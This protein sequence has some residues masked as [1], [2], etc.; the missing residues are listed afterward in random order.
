MLLRFGVA[1]HLSIRD[2]QELSLVA[3]P[4]RD[5][6]AG[7]IDTPQPGLRLLPAALIYGANASGKSNFVASLRWLRGAVLRSHAEFRPD[8]GV[9]RRPF[10]LDDRSK[11]AASRWDIDFI[12]GGVP[13]HYEVEANDAAFVGERL[14]ARPEGRTQLWFD[15]EGCRFSF[16]RNL[17]GRNSTI[18][19]LTRSNSLFLST[20]MQNGHEALTA[21]GR[22]F[23]DLAIQDDGASRLAEPSPQQ[24]LDA[25]VTQI[26]AALGTGIVESRWTDRSL[27]DDL[28]MGSE[29]AADYLRTLLPGVVQA[30]LPNRKA[31]ELAHPDSNGRPRFFRFEDES[32]GTRRLIRLLPA[33]FPALDRGGTM[34]VDELNASLHT[35]ACETLLALVSLRRSNPK[36]AQLVATTHDTNLL[37]SKLLRR[38]QIWL[39]EKDPSGASQLYPL[40]DIHTRKGDNLARGYLQGRY[41]A[42][43]F[44]GSIADLLGMN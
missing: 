10:A 3:S 34:V 28:G 30:S 36:G 38:D 7:L 40:T 22:Y 1:N 6:E 35:Q 31:L 12:V 17:R 18:A 32:E 44:S 33:M 21:V 13:Y 16:G 24:P 37:H 8:G 25:R 19:A 23:L 2:R 29:G 39:V 9:P 15:R 43:P 42:V 41:G 11:G 14:L 26:L 5:D 27:I 20:A 4:L